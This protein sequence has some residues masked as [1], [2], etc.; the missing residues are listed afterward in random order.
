MKDFGVCTLAVGALSV[1]L[2]HAAQ[3]YD[4]DDRAYIVP[5]FSYVLADDARDADDG[6]GGTLAIGKPVSP[7]LEIE[8]RGSYLQYSAHDNRPRF[9][10][11][12]IGPKP[13]DFEV[14][15]GGIGA[16]YFFESPGR[17][18]FLH[19]DAMVG[20]STLYNAGIGFDWGSEVRVRF[21]ALYHWDTD[22]A[23]FEEPQF[24]LGF[25]IPIGKHTQTTP[26]PASVR[27][28]PPVAPPPPAAQC[29]DG[30]DNDSDGKVDFP[31]DPGCTSSDDNDEAD[32]PCELPSPGQAMSLDGCK[33]GDTIV[34]RGVNFEFDKA[35]LTV[36][37]KALLD[38]VVDALIK[39]PDIQVE[40][41]GHTDS[42]GSDAYNQKLSERRAMSVMQYLVEHGIAV[43]R[44]SSA[45]FGESMPVADNAT[46]QGRE[47]NR[48]VELKVLQTGV[49]AAPMEPAVGEGTAIPAPVLEPIA[50]AMTVSPAVPG[51]MAEPAV[52]S[53][54][55]DSE[56]AA[57]EPTPT[58][59][60]STSG[61]AVS[62][63]FMVFE[64]PNLTVA[65]GTTV[66][67]T[68]TDGSNH[69]V[70]F[71]DQQSP[72]L[73]HEA[74]YS[75]RFDTPGVYPYECAIHGKRMSGS[76]T[77]R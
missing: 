32:P 56:P 59:P 75:R 76:I 17:G 26:P 38:L 2:A 51:T 18:F 11:Q 48:R 58:P 54:A 13:E 14:T 5:M 6:I 70:K 47:L 29:G 10:G 73:R 44:L 21:E 50:G 49:G 35:N 22:Q 72:R 43:D 39:R 52:E 42:K 4:I 68:N 74:S 34:L 69:V 7:N 25:R 65:P 77:V 30:V 67:W 40:I 45:G 36:N 60:A 20:D 24:N 64:P 63:G 61:A 46:D 66:T 27:V 37:A 31:A 62:I 1:G 33:T 9:L 55:V 71:A 23:D 57:G 53:A 28:V 19:G 8:L 41:D 16:S 12:P 3:A 15:A